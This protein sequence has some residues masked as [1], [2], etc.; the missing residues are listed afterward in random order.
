MSV[1]TEIAFNPSFAATW[2][3]KPE[4]QSAEEI[5]SLS[6]ESNHL[7]DR[8]HYQVRNGKLF[9]PSAHIEVRDSVRGENKIAGLER[10]AIDSTCE[11]ANHNDEGVAVW[12]SPPDARFYPTTKI[13][14]NEIVGK[15]EEKIVLNRAI[16]LDVNAEEECLQIAHDLS[17]FSTSHPLRSSLNPLD[18]IRGGLFILRQSSLHW[19]RLLEEVIPDLNLEIV[20]TDEDRCIKEK[21]VAQAHQLYR[22]HLTEDGYLNAAALA[23]EATRMGMLGSF[24]SSCPELFGMASGGVMFIGMQPIFRLESKGRCGKRPKCCNP[25][26][27]RKCTWEATDGEWSEIA[28]DK[29]TCC[30]DCGWKP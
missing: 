18:Q 28:A 21:M 16:I 15:G 3:G 20:R 11:W 29:L 26:K 27:D 14:V 5:A 13:I 22:K 19:T 25:D 6:L 1:K 23:E 30:P 10:Q 9:S 4:Q 12:I 7:P 24:V 8:Y 2:Q 17:K